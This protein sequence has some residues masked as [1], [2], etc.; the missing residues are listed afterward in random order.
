MKELTLEEFITAGLSLSNLLITAL[1][2]TDLLGNIYSMFS[3][4][5]EIQPAQQRLMLI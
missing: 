5:S 3:C 2:L 4:I 1:G